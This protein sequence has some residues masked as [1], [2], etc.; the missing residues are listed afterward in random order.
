MI[1]TYASAALICAVSL[2]VGRAVL[3]LAARREWSWLEPAVGL[4]AVLTVTGLLARAPGHGT[5]ATL[6]LVALI[7]VAALVVWRIGVR[8]FRGIA[9]E[10]TNAGAVWWEGLPVALVIALVLA[11]PFAVSGRWGLLGVGFNNDLGLHLAW[12]EWLRSGFGPEPDPGYPLGPHGLA[13]ATA[14]VPGI[15][16]GQAFLGEIVAI[17]VMTG[18]TALGA[19]RTLTPTRRT[20]AAAL[21]ALPYLAAS[22]YAQA[23]FKEL[24][25]ALL[26]LAFAIY[27]TTFDARATP[28][29][30]SQARGGPSPDTQHRARRDVSGVG[31]PLAWLLPPLA[32]AGGIFFSYSFAGIAWPVAIAAL[33]SLTLPEVRRALRPRSLL[34]FLLRPVTLLT[35]AVLAGLAILVTVV[36]PFGF[37]S[38]FNKVA[39]SNTYGPVSPLEALGIWPASNYRLDAAGGAR[40]PGLA[41]T[42]AILALL[43]GVAWWARRREL[44]IPIAL[45]AAW[46]LYLL[47]LPS[48]GDYSQAKALMIISPL[49]AL[50]IVRPLLE[51]FPRLGSRGRGLSGPSPLLSGETPPP[52]PLRAA[53]T[54]LSV[55]F[56]AGAVYSSFLALRDAPVG[57]PGHGSELQAFLPI[58]HGQPVLYAGQDRYAAYGLLGADTHVPLVEFP[59]D[60]VSPNPEK[61]FDTGDAYSPIDF[62]SF[63]RGTLDRFPYVITSRAA[64]NSQAPP[65][66]KRVASTDSYVLWKRTGPTPEDRHVLLEGTEAGAYAGCAAPEIRILLAA[67]GHAGL[68]PDAVIGHKDDWD[69][70]SILGLDAETSQT[71]QLPAG[72]WN[73]SL[74]Y[75][76][77]FGLTLSAPGF[78]EE[79]AAALD[80]QRPNTISLGNN[81]QFWSAGRY[82]SKGGSVRF[83]VATEDASTLQSLSGYTGKAYLGELVAVPAEPHRTVPLAAACDQWIDWYEAAEAP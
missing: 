22:Y 50:V 20:I 62:D 3:S 7:A 51:E 54:V 35:I 1:A 19:L 11:I 41:G 21:V 18:L 52:A 37:A 83:T 29:A 73:L 10:R 27:L 9:P 12:A 47:S 24:A 5:S 74:Q 59:D 2:L 68:F 38:S 53:W 77:P 31:P 61:P 67:N 28:A 79:L 42:I 69:G 40:L 26:V 30:G 15:G 65:N 44:T 80:G 32:L 72:S 81:G 60:A 71:L 64:W 33:W 66:F 23:A 14:V 36:G 76:S 55:A 25:E 43:A 82:E 75:F 63:S 45:G 46:L 78:S 4:G 70:G 13:V 16:L 48:A 56:I 39:G 49:A 34:R 17:G 57:P 58:L 6:G 8:P